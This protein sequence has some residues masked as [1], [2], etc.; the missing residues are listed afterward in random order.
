MSN[1][2]A[3]SR[4]GA[5][6]S[7]PQQP[8]SGSCAPRPFARAPA[9]QGERRRAFGV[10]K[11][12]PS[13]GSSLERRLGTVSGKGGRM[14]DLLS[15]R[16]CS[17]CLSYSVIIAYQWTTLNIKTYEVKLDSSASQIVP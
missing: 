2:W 9:G 8:R 16:Q 12:G 1:S 13:A 17:V 5:A 6:R 7:A 10:T 15:S 11:K 4:R 14:M 3:D